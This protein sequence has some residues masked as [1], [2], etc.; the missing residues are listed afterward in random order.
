MALV[1]DALI[2]CESP[3]E[4]I[5]QWLDRHWE[6]VSVDY[7]TRHVCYHWSNTPSECYMA[8]F[9]LSSKYDGPVL[10]PE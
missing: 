7:D 6:L 2:S 9:K 5:G 1:V 10:Y 8:T 3:N 4:D